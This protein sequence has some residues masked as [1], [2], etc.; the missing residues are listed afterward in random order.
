MI[1]RACTS[2]RKVSSKARGACGEE[3][4]C[5]SIEFSAIAPYL[6]DAI[7]YRLGFELLAKKA[8]QGPGRG[9]AR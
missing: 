5:A 6:I 3:S 1:A 9:W 2:G 4:S 7:V 8:P